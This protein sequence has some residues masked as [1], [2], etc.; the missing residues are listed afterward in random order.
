M[1]DIVLI[2][3]E[4]P[5]NIGSV[6][7]VMKNFSFT[8]LVLVNPQ[9]DYKADEAIRRSKHAQEILLKAKT[10]KKFDDIAKRYDYLIAT[11]AKLGTDYNIPRSPL[12]AE[13]FAEKYHLLNK[14]IDFKTNTPTNNKTNI[15]T[16][17]QINTETN[18][19]T[20]S[21]TNTQINT[22]TNNKTNSKTNTKTE[23]NIKVDIKLA[24]LVGREG[25]GLKNDE[26]NK[27]DFIV[28]V[29]SSTKYSTLN[30]SHALS[31][32]L[33]ELFKRSGKKTAMDKIT[34]ITMKEKQIVLQR[35]NEI[36]GLLHFTTKDK[37]E[38]QRKLWKRI[39]GK[40]MLTK[41]EAFALLGFLKK[42]TDSLKKKTNTLL[43]IP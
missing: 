4:H 20:N 25:I 8:K 14:E 22:E 17:T 42:I 15:K 29:P 3:P 19:K 35:I 43:K 39:V 6:A 21:K 30:I 5:G 26:I 12:T 33:Y 41:R 31:I 40:S 16:N 27:C 13:E 28:T 32:I 23:I 34:P 37:K 36:L 10:L 9:C 2:E 24:L 11:T 38:T 1:I 18:S 7:R